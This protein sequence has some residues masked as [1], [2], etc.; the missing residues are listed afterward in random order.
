MGPG[1]RG[2]GKDHCFQAWTTSMGLCDAWRT[3]NPTRRQFTHTSAAHYTHARLHY[4]LL[5]ST[6]MHLTT[7]SS[8][9]PR[10][11]SDHSLV[12]VGLAAPSLGRRL[13]WRLNASFL[14]NSQF[15]RFLDSAINTY[16]QENEASDPTQGILWAAGKAFFRG[17]AKVYIRRDERRKQEEVTRL[18]ANIM[19]IESRLHCTPSPSLE[20]QLKLDQVSL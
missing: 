5:P 3:W 18:E 20:R 12:I 15:T 7:C 9:L 13:V 4:I 19:R 2:T 8:I 6:D 16:F 14:K 10:G 17:L 11:I 1:V